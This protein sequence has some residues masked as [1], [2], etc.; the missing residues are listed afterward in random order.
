MILNKNSILISNGNGIEYFQYRFSLH[1]KL[2]I[3]YLCEFFQ[4]VIKY[5][6]QKPIINDSSIEN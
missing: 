4:D 1:Y 5:L 6:L 2:E 3:K